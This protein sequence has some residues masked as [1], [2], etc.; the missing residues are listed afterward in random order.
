MSDDERSKVPGP[1]ILRVPS[2]T[3]EAEVVFSAEPS[4]P[5]LDDAARRLA[6]AIASDMLLYDAALFT[7]YRGGPL[8][9]TLAAQVREGYEL[10][11]GRSGAG[12]QRGYAA[13]LAE[14][15]GA[16]GTPL[17][18]AAIL[19]A[20]GPDAVTPQASP[21]PA[22]PRGLRLVVRRGV[23]E[24]KTFVVQG[25]DATVGRTPDCTIC[26]PS[27]SLSRRHAVLVFRQG[28]WQVADL[29]SANGT[30]VNERPAEASTPVRAGDRL[31][32][33]DVEC[34]VVG[35]SVGEAGTPGATRKPWWKFW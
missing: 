18:V 6:R 34:E 15:T 11:V 23:E 5:P 9:G 21:I 32:F 7:A 1:P 27:V 10:F 20:L 17:D 35:A 4:E 26:L 16:H 8:G 19:E 33:G 28:G 31:R 13:V 29:S 22:E 24:G 14:V 2:D 25:T 12:H 3:A 30:F